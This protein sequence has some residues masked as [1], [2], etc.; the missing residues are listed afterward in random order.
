MLYILSNEPEYN[1]YLNNKILLQKI[2]QEILANSQL[3]KILYTYNY[4]D[5]WYNMKIGGCSLSDIIFLNI[6]NT[7]K[8]QTIKDLI[9]ATI[10]QGQNIRQTSNTV[11]FYNNV[12]KSKFGNKDIGG[13][14]EYFMNIL[15]GYNDGNK[16]FEDN[17]KG[18]LN[19]KPAVDKEDTIR[20]K[21]WDLMK[22]RNHL[23]LPILTAPQNDMYIISVP[24]QIVI[25]S[26][27]RYGQH[28]EGN[29]SAMEKM[30]NDY[31]TMIGNFYGISATFIKDSEKI[32]NTHAHIQ[33]DTR[34]NFP[35]SGDQHPGTTQ[36]PVIKWVY[37]AIGAIASQNGSGAYANGTDVYWVVYHALGSD[38]SFSVFSHE[39]AHNQ[40][41]YYFYEGYGRRWN[42]W[43]ED[44]ADSN[45]AQDLGDGSFVFNIR[46][47]SSVTSDDSNNIKLERIIGSDKIYSYYKE[48]FETYYVLDYL[49]G[50]AFLQLTP[51]QQSKVA[52]QVSYENGANY[53]QGGQNTI[54]SK[55]SADQFSKMNLKDMEDLWDNGIA[56]R[57][58]GKVSGNGPGSYGG[59]NHYS[60]YWYQPH[61]NFGR[62]DSYSFK[63]LGFEMLGVGGYSNGYVIYRSGKSSNDL[64]ALRKI[65]QDN[66]MTW[67]KYKM[68][69]FKNVEQNLN[70]IPYFD[71]QEVIQLFKQSLEKDAAN[72]NRNNT[73]SLRRTLYGVVKRATKDFETGTIYSSGEEIEISSAQQFVEI[74][75]SAEWGN[76][77]LT[78]DLDF[79]NIKTTDNTY[80]NKAFV[81]RI[82][83]NGFKIKGLTKT[84]FNEMA[85]AEIQDLTIEEPVYDSQ[86]TSIL[87]KTSKNIVLNNVVTNNSNL[88]LPF[89]KNNN[90]LIQWLGITAI[91]IKDN[92]IKTVQDFIEISNSEDSSKKKMNYVLSNDIDLS[93]ISN[94]NSIINGTFEG[95]INGNG[96]T[97]SNLKAP[98]FNKLT[99]IVENLN[100]E[101]VT[102]KKSGTANLAAIAGTTQNATLNNIK[103][104][105][106]EIEGWD[107]ISAVVG[108]ANATTFNKISATNINIKASHYYA[109]GVIGRSYNS[110]MKDI[111]VSGILKVKDTHNGGV[112]GAMNKD[113]LQNIYANVDVVRYSN[114][115]S[116][117]KNAG[118]YGA[119]ET[120][121]ISIKN[122]IVVGNM[123][124]SLYK[125]T[126][127]TNDTEK[128]QITKY[129][130]NVFE[131]ENSTGI[132][133]AEISNNI[134][135][136]TKE[137]LQDENF[138]INELN[139]STGIWDF[140]ELKNG[141]GPK[142]K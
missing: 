127:A 39:T 63:R 125:I 80:I 12:L 72:G 64:D 66:T 123:S 103:I 32:L 22:A 115:D 92:E 121:G 107:N 47:D 19:Q 44:H 73:N 85:Y 43:A 13:F 10:S 102:I 76:Y 94:V 87:S 128:N 81:G 60:I 6:N 74:L 122:A 79:S 20:Y 91:N 5:K 23:I 84:L 71:S 34:F 4:F 49:T 120:E 108:L 24:S 46:R 25:G 133:N 140:S 82:N 142:L 42:T 61:N 51:E 124:E 30:I 90:V 17:F 110:V 18:I 69:R 114:G 111:F 113:T 75:N 21:A 132:S 119:I 99:G 106:V 70:N 15:A 8:D 7:N 48:M 98:L 67:K 95:K 16:W 54:Y 139:F 65:T 116:R 93:S 1:L 101:N 97:L 126:P 131:Y 57:N 40:D 53:E 77:K 37:E 41:G 26:M 27:N 56:L 138:Y 68:N 130:D 55:I 137:N 11:G 45:I 62:P 136:A 129:L 109:G 112:I 83:G 9:N 36:D 78:K 29:T 100:I 14:L 86:V 88:N 96:H 28:I 89:I 3:E 35:Q 38:F 58:A 135:N 117:N 50:Q 141:N 134:K 2:K 59:D 105:N 104:N 52:V 31:A 33:Y 118:L